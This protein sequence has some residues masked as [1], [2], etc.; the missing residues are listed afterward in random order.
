MAKQTQ[1]KIETK[2]GKKR[3]AVTTTVTRKQKWTKGQVRHRIAH[4]DRRIGE[5]TDALAAVQAER[6]E[7]AGLKDQI[8][9]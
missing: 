4:L 3:L 9:D 5:L 6:D 2:D 7:L 8:D 1:R